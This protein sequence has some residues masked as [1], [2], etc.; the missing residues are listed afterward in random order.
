MMMQCN[1]EITE[2]PAGQAEII[3]LGWAATVK[4]FFFDIQTSANY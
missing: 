1:V 3:Q 2:R 4:P